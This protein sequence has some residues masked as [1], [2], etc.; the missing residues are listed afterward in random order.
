M[1]H[2]PL[3]MLWLCTCETLCK[4]EVKQDSGIFIEKAENRKF[5]DSTDSTCAL[6]SNSFVEISL[7]VVKVSDFHLCRDFR[8]FHD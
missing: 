2:L 3:P 6:I 8:C 7:F 1:F 5:M 4:H